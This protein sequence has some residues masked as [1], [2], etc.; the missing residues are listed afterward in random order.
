MPS[1]TPSS[2]PRA[3]WTAGGGASAPPPWKGGSSRALTFDLQT[4]H[5]AIPPHVTFDQ[6]AR[7]LPGLRKR[8]V[9]GRNSW[10]TLLTLRSGWPPPRRRRRCPTPP[11]FCTPRP[12]RNSRNLRYTIYYDVIIYLSVVRGKKKKA[13]AIQTRIK[14]SSKR[15]LTFRTLPRPHVRRLS[16]G[17]S[18]KA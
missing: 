5:V 2:R 18:T 1:A 9:C 17:R 10:K 8:G 15:R 16:S 12:R 11:V 4:S 14:N 7:W 6:T 3:V 13:L